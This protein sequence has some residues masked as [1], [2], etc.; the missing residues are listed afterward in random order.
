MR[1]YL[2]CAFV[3]V[4]VFAV[5]CK[6]DKGMEKATVTDTGDIAK[7]G[8]G[9]L[10]KLEDGK[11]VRPDYLPSAYQHD[12]YKVKIKFNSDGEG[13]I[14]NTYPTKKF[15]ENIQLTDIKRDQD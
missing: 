8:C 5:S 2:L 10:L 4:S 9:Y 1:K 14:C 12:G 6:K 15:I 7:D 3:L 13:D 11:L